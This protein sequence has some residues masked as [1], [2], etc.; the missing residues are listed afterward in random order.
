MNQE[1]FMVAYDYGAGGLWGLMRAGS[2]EEIHRLY[3]ELVIVYERPPWMTDQ[4]YSRMVQK[5]TYDLDSPPTGMLKAIVADRGR[6]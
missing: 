2:E 6:A 4:D 1:T 3:P 5:D